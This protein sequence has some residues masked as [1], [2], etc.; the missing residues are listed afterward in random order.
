MILIV[1]LGNPGKE[2]ENTRHNTG[3]I[4]LEKI[5]KANDFPN[6]KNDMKLKSFRS[7]GELDGEKVE[8][9]LP[10]IFMNNSGNA[11]CGIID[12]KK[13]LKNL[14]V[15]YDDLDLPLG[16]LKISYDRSSG[17]HNGLESV[18]KRVKSKE[19]VRIRIGVSPSTPTGKFRKPKGEEAV[20]KFLLGTF[21]E[22]ELKIIKNMSK[23]VTEIITMVSSEG[24]DKAMSVFN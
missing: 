3:R 20:L 4:I 7:K 12:D 16:S 19:F 10:N 21:K 15:V 17:G 11:V 6:W 8:F 14:V 9:L 22:D 13:K 1:G 24:K 5:A 23:K 18:I 2:Y